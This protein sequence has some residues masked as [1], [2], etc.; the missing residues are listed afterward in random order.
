[1][2]P[3]ECILN[4]THNNVVAT[5]TK[6]SKSEWTHFYCFFPFFSHAYILLNKCI[7]RQLFFSMRYD[8]IICNTSSDTLLP[9]G[10]FLSFILV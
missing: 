1:M 6:L 9:M 7:A 8:M 5:F 10:L 2:T 4:E 3:M